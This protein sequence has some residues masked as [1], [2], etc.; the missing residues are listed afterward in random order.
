M[1]SNLRK[2]ISSRKVFPKGIKKE[3]LK[4]KDSGSFAFL[5]KIAL[6]YKIMIVADNNDFTVLYNIFILVLL[7][8]LGYITIF[9]KKF[10]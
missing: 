9:N 8:S 4:I 3:G 1:H 6:K 2:S 10:F 5:Y 7:F